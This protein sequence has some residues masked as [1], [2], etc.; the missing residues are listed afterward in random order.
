MKQSNAIINTWSNL[1]EGECEKDAEWQNF[2]CDGF[3]LSRYKMKYTW[4]MYTH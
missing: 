3:C 4:A 1:T 2:W